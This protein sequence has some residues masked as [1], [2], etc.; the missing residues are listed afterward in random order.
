MSGNKE[1]TRSNLKAPT[2]Y[3]AFSLGEKYCEL[4]VDDL[5]FQPDEYL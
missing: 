5:H 1:L 4:L 2:H 3:Y